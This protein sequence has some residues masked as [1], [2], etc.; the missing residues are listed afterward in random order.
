M[1]SWADLVP[2]EAEVVG[3]WHA[4]RRLHYHI[5]G[6]PVIYGLVDH[7][8]FVVLSKSKQMSDLSPRMF[9]LL[10]ELMEYP[11]IMKYMPG[12][13][14]L[15]GMVDALSRA[16]F[17][18]ASTLCSDPLDLQYHSLNRDQGQVSHKI[19]FPTIALGSGDPCPYDPSLQLMY[20]AAS[21]DKE[22][23]EI[24]DNVVVGHKW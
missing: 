6:A 3:Y 20:E 8:P 15:I 10:Q 7:R 24:V 16:P 23:M 5:R 9:K 14:A 12:R 11:F 13:G 4:S 19:C 21:K 22:Y 2:L 18:D 1:G 17:E